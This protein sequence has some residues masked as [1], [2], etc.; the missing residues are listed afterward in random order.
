MDKVEKHSFL[1]NGLRLE[2]ELWKAPEKADFF[3]E[4]Y[5]KC[6]P[7]TLVFLHGM[8]GSI[9][10]IRKIYEP[11]P[12]IQVIVP[13]QQGHGESEADWDTLDFDC[14]ADDII[15]LLEE[16]KIETA[17]FAGISMGAAVCLNLAVRYPQRVKKLFL[18]R[19]AWTEKPMEED[20]RKAYADM[21]NCL[22]EGGIEAFYKTEGWN[23]VKEPSAYTRNA[24]TCTFE[25]TSCLKY[26]QKYLILPNKVPVKNVEEIRRIQSPTVILANKND[27]CHPFEYGIHIHNLIS[28]SRFFEIPDKD[29]DGTGHNKEINRIIREEI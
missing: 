19:N 1:S 21:G 6:P 13:N 5:R 4:S 7:D 16:L 2:Y 26:W 27:F 28:N 18:I 17:Y 15:A 10:Q 20:R 3:D 11:I 25:D 24:F 14:M 8:G 23:I 9:E 12:G 29:Q 22:R